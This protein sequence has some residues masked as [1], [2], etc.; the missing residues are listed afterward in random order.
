MY[1]QYSA[2]AAIDSRGA[3]TFLHWPFA[4]TYDNDFQNRDDI[5]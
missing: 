5:F 1:M 4:M 2:D 3:E